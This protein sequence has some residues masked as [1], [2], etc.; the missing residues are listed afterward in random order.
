MKKTP[1]I[2]KQDRFTGPTPAEERKSKG[3]V[4][5]IIAATEEPCRSQA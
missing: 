1:G 2:K 4:L 5:S 3:K